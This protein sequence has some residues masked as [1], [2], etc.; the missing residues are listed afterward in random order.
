[1]PEDVWDACEEMLVSTYGQ[2]VVISTP[3]GK[4]NRF[5]QC[6][7]PPKKTDDL[8]DWKTYSYNYR[9][10]LD[11]INPRTGRPQIN[12]RW[13]RIR[14]N[15]MPYPMWRQEYLAEFVEDVNQYFS[16]QIINSVFNSRLGWLTMPRPGYQYFMGID[17]AKMHD[18]T[19]IWVNEVLHTNPVTGLPLKEP[20]IRAVHIT[21]LKGRDYIIQLPIIYQLANH[22]KPAKIYFDRTGVGEMPF[23]QLLYAGY[24]VEGISF[25][26]GKKVEMYGNIYNWGSSPPEIAGWGAK[27]QIPMHEEAYDQFCN[28]EYEIPKQK[29][30]QTGQVYLGDNYHIRA[31]AGRHDD[32]PTA[33]ALA[34]LGTMAT[35]M[36]PVARA[37]PHP[38]HVTAFPAQRQIDAVMKTLGTTSKRGYSHRGRRKTSWDV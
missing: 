17:V 36:I 29:S 4:N 32:Y 15:R 18:S 34:C 22:W 7:H 19:V 25:T 28:L 3:R 37:L 1:M 38:M 24:P 30:S 14:K 35:V 20:H 6:F 5:Y 26:M 11:V 2:E 8:P 16:E 21:E 23:E 27:F 13:V 31:P 33:C 9:V 12:E 10:G